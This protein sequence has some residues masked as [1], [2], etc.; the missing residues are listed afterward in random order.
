MDP[1]QQ[2]VQ[3]IIHQE[4]PPLTQPSQDNSSEAK[5]LPDDA[6]ERLQIHENSASN[7]DSLPSQ[8]KI[9]LDVA[10]PERDDSSA[11]LTPKLEDTP[12]PV[13][14][15]DPGPV[16]SSPQQQPP[17]QSE[18]VVPGDDGNNKDKT[19]D[20]GSL[21]TSNT[22]TLTTTTRSSRRKANKSSMSEGPPSSS[23]TGVNSSASNGKPKVP[24]N[25]SRSKPS[26]LSKFFKILVPCVSF[27]SRSH[28]IDIDSAKVLAVNENEKPGIIKDPEPE[29]RPSPA[30]P[31][32]DASSSP[33]VE[34]LTSTS[35]RLLPLAILP[36]GDS[37]EDS[38]PTPTRAL[39]PKSETAGVTSGAVQP[40]GSTGDGIMSPHPHVHTHGRN[41]TVDGSAAE[42][43]ES[44][45]TSFTE[46]EDGD[47]GNAMD[48]VEDEEDRLIMNG[49]AGIPV[50][51]VSG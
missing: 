29:L 27:S 14:L 47:D 15:N 35:A 51:P 16:P 8:D 4:N 17:S 34:P 39:L 25:S 36:P 23:S 6:T 10:S 32:K 40:P 28:S 38:P 2:D 20:K 44:D 18:N 49:G 21:S 1:I 46:D 12:S 50:G 45:E 5:V 41:H 31:P 13:G 9:Q 7:D 11:S 48:E 22:R 19:G 33:G 3:D 30:E 43:E 26:F 42:G 37:E 24:P